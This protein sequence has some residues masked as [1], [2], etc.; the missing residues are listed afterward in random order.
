MKPCIAITLGDPAGIGPEII[1]KALHD[2]R[3]RRAC[4]PFV[5]G[6]PLRVRMGRPSRV[7]GLFAIQ[8]L[9]EGLR[10]V[11]SGR[12]QALVTPRKGVRT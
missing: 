6:A 4:K 12:A 10:L 5:V 7:A 9:Q 8:A 11:R 3:I 1:A 2:P